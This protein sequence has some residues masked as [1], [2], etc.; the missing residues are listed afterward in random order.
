MTLVIAATGHR[1]D[2]LG[3]Y[4]SDVHRRLVELAARYL[5]LEQPTCVISG[6][7]LGWDLAF[8]DAALLLGL[9]VH[10]A[11]PFEGNNP[12]G[13]SARKINGSGS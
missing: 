5:D 1:P 7:A 13:R 12:V 8:A 2:K 3:G 9:P 11:V 10:G 6:L 4:G